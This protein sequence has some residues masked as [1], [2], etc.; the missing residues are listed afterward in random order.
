MGHGEHREEMKIVGSRMSLRQR[1]LITMIKDRTGRMMSEMM[2]DMLVREGIAAGFL[3]DDGT[4]KPEF[5]HA[6]NGNM[7]LLRDMD[8]MRKRK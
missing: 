1:A 2:E 5:E 4:I 6:L 7:A 3:N 8:N